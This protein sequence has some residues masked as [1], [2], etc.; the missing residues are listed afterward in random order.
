MSDLLTDKE[1][2]LNKAQTGDNMSALASARTLTVLPR[3]DGNR[4]RSAL[5]FLYESKLIAKVD[6]FI[7]EAKLIETRQHIVDLRGADLNRAQLSNANLMKANLGAANLERANLSGAFLSTA[8]LGSANLKS[9]NLSDASLSTAD[10]F[11][12]H[13]DAAD[14]RGA[15]LDEAITWLTLP[16]PICARPT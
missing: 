11:A 13:L 2:P 9:A 4:K 14:L 5:Q 10:L 3:L 1:Q 7:S 8:D 6:A 16:G 12:T 15:S